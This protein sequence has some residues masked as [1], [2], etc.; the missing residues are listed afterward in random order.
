MP[1]TDW[2]RLHDRLADRLGAVAARGGRALLA[3][4]LDGDVEG[5]E[6]L[7]TWGGR[8]FALVP[9]ARDAF[10]AA[11]SAGIGMARF[12]EHADD[13][14]E[15]IRAAER[16]ARDAPPDGLREA[17]SRAG[18]RR[19]PVEPEAFAEGRLTLHYQPQVSLADGSIR[20]LEALVRIHRLDEEGES[21][22]VSGGTTAT[23]Q[24]HEIVPWTIEQVRH[25]LGAWRG[26][27]LETVPVAINLPLPSLDDR[28]FCRRIAALLTADP[29]RAADFEIELTEEQPPGDLARVCD[30]LAQLKASGLQLALDDVGTGFAGVSLLDRLPLDSLKIDRSFVARLPEQD[31]AREN[32]RT[33]V[34]LG[35]ARDLR[36]VGE[37]VELPEQRQALADLGCDLFQGYVF[38]A[39]VSAEA[40][41][42]LLRR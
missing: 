31:E 42:R 32:V 29:G 26:A 7:G 20:G 6:A 39:P 19:P 17:Q 27:G 5:A 30:D 11:G 13:P 36:V 24:I 4:G 38:S 16:A 40:I 35:R 28:A 22:W 21:L 33:L 14:A 9:E 10:A 3:C 25:D 41:A 8:R 2:L 12:P 23:E 1:L 18:G 15:L 34:A 37:G